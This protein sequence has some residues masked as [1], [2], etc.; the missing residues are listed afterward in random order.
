M[1][2][3]ADPQERWVVYCQARED[4][5]GDGKIEIGFGHHGAVFGDDLSLYLNLDDGDG[6]TI[7]RYLARDSEGSNLVI[8]D[9]GGIFLVN[10][11]S[12]S[13]TGLGS[14]G[15]ILY[16]DP[17][18]SPV[19]FDERGHV[20]F[21]RNEKDSFEFVLRDLRSGQETVLPVRAKNIINATINESGAWI[22][23]QDVEKDTNG[24]GSID[25]PK[26]RTTKASGSCTGPA[27]SYSTYGYSGDEPVT[28]ALPV[29]GNGKSIALPG[30]YI[31]LDNKILMQNEQGGYSIVDSA[32]NALEI[33]PAS[34]NAELLAVHETLERVLV[35]C[36]DALGTHNAWVYGPNFSKSLGFQLAPLGTQP[37]VVRGTEEVPLMAFGR[38]LRVNLSTA[39]TKSDCDKF[40][41]LDG[42]LRCPDAVVEVEK[43]SCRYEPRVCATDEYPVVLAKS[44]QEALLVPAKVADSSLGRSIPNGPMRWVRGSSAVGEKANTA[45]EKV[46]ESNAKPGIALSRCDKDSTSLCVFDDSGLGTGGALWARSDDELWSAGYSDLLHFI[47]DRW[48]LAKKRG[49]WISA[50]TGTKDGHVWVAAGRNVQ[51]WT[52]KSFGPA[53][54][55]PAEVKALHANSSNSVWAVGSGMVQHWNG[56]R[57]LALPSPG[58]ERVRAVY[59]FSDKNAWVVLAKGA[60]LHWNG[61]RWKKSANINLGNSPQ[62]WGC[63]DSNMWASN[64]DGTLF[65][66]NGKAWKNTKPFGK[67]NVWSIHGNSCDQVWVTVSRN[68]GPE[69]YKFEFS[70]LWQWNGRTWS[71]ISDIPS[72]SRVQATPTALWIHSSDGNL[73]LPLPS[74]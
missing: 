29:S 68:S 69:D 33:V 65:H 60:V 22:T 43:V 6:E 67:S 18:N 34:C 10:I 46:I 30:P 58:S 40:E 63:S 48:T 5:D 61:K 7:K 2:K 55:L 70:H 32:L 14:L 25:V 44:E 47:D 20:L 59:S 39:E 31:V 74:R 19:S 12:G 41:L 54:T 9:E 64:F 66:W 49:D 26:V 53:T 17:R 73:R 51:M 72:L 24:N 36:K 11:P 21:H 52:G 57:W 45:G 50:F 16:K 62:I 1:F 71:K 8:E 37:T 35:G 42:T 38:N 13:R 28:R 27:M 56:S 23:F 4:S 15:G 3:D